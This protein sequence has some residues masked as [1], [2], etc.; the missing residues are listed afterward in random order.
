VSRPKLL[1]LTRVF[2]PVLAIGAV[3][4][5]NLAKYLSRQGWDVSV[6]TTHPSLWRRLD[7]PEKATRDVELERIRCIFTGHQWRSLAS[8]L[9]CWSE[10]PGWVIGGV[11][12]RI[13]HHLSI[14]GGIG[15][16]KP[17]ERACA[18]LTSNDVDLILASGPPFSAFML[19]RRL[20]NRLGRPYVLDYRDLWSRNF[21]RPLPAVTQREATVL[22]GCAGIITVSPSW[23]LIMDREFGVGHKRHVITNAYDPEDLMPVRPHH[24]GHFSIVYAGSFRPPKRVIMPVMAALQRL[25]SI[26]STNFQ[27]LFFHYY[28]KDS[29]HVENAAREFGV[30]DRVVL[31]GKVPRAEALA[32]LRGSSIAV[33]ITSV[34]MAERGEDNGMIP[35]KLY[36]SIGLRNRVLLIA[37]RGSDARKVLDEAGFGRSFAAD[38]ID[39]I[40]S[41]IA[42]SFANGLSTQTTPEPYSWPYV[43]KRLDDTLR[44]VLCEPRLNGSTVNVN[45]SPASQS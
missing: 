31:H 2:S 19:A 21:Y 45:A 4:T 14:D 33:V 37:P 24:F 27:N 39:N 18:H 43:V 29:D 20:S 17:A 28:G 5:W 12:R 30:A 26:N 32:A 16:I 23:G 15:W 25:N 11:S 9:K 13:A 8:G 42:E 40:A 34:S 41:Y 3:R 7:N 35:A 6:V 1:F 10:G 36:E 44:A 22:A 38:E